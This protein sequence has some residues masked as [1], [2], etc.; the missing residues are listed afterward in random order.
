M[1]ERLLE[2]DGLL[3]LLAGLLLGRDDQLVRL[4]LGGEE[5]FLLERLGVAFGVLDEPR[6]LLFGAADGVGGDAFAVRHP[7]GEHGRSHHQRDGQ[8]DDVSEYRQHA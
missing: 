6:G 8:I 2:R 3:T 1:V 4:L 7:E 5:R